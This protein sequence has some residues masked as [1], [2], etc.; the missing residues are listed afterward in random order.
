M[1]EWGNAEEQ[2]GSCNPVPKKL[3]AP[4]PRCQGPPFQAE[5]LPW[6]QLKG[7]QGS[8]VGHSRKPA[9]T[10]PSAEEADERVP[11]PHLVTGTPG[12]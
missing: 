6:E 12:P 9:P 3:H 1:G 4:T 5:P 11:A 10:A 7:E 2:R 8:G